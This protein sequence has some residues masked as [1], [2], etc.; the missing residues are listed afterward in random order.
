MD[1]TI[2]AKKVLT[3][4]EKDRRKVT[5]QRNK[6]ISNAKFARRIAEREPQLPLSPDEREQKKIELAMMEADIAL[7]KSCSDAQYQLNKAIFAM[8]NPE[9]DFFAM[10]AAIKSGETL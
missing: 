4:A 5:Q 3:Q 10:L 8:R 9:Q 6:Q 2:R 7:L 1:C